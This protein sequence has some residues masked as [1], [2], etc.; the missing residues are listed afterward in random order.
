[1]SKSVI[2]YIRRENYRKKVLFGAVYIEPENSIYFNRDS[3]V[4]LEDS[5]IHLNCGHVC[6]LGDFKSRTGSLSDILVRDVHVDAQ[7]DVMDF[8]TGPRV[9]KDKTTN[10]MGSEMLHFLKTTQMSKI[11]PSAFANLTIKIGIF[12][13]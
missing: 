9:S 7:V 6:L 8:D 2:F 4:E 10:T 13:D 3:Y 1:M 12:S 5:L 11:H